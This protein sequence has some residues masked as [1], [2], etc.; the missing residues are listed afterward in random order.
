MKKILLTSASLAALAF[1][2]PAVQA[3]TTIDWDFLCDNL[4]IPDRVD[5]KQALGGH[6]WAKNLIVD[7]DDA[8]DIVQTA[9]N[10]GNLINLE[11]LTEDLGTISQTASVSQFA[12]NLITAEEGGY[13]EPD[14]VFYNIEQAATNVVNSVTADVAI[15]VRQSVS[16]NQTAL[17]TILGGSGGYDADLGEDGELLADTQAAVNAA[18]LVDIRAINNEIVQI[19]TGTQTAINTAVFEPSGFGHFTEVPDVYDLTQSATNVTNN[20]TIG[21]FDISGFCACEFE[22]DQYADA[23]QIAVNTLSALGDVQNIVQS[24]TNVANSISMPSADG[25]ED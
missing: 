13:F 14:S 7:V 20:V 16:S 11:D 21:E 24:A 3:T 2:A 10:A 8:Q 4:C 23:G 5:L 17:N 9:V 25:D 19:S 12:F 22:V 15:N 18:N 1:A 6:Q